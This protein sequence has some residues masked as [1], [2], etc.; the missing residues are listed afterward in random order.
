MKRFLHGHATHPDAG[1]ALAL[2]AAQ[3]DAQRREPG[4]A[5]DP[6]LGWFYLTDHYAPHAEAL[7]ADAQRR[8]PG[9][10]WVGASGIGVAASGVEYIDEPALSLLLGELPRE[11]FRVFSGASPLGAF[12]AH[13]ANVH[14]DPATNDLAELVSDLAA[15]TGAHYLFGGLASGRSRTLHMADAVLG[16]GVSGVAF[17]PEVALVSRVT[18]GCQPLGP[19]RIVTAADR[20]VIMT[21][22]NHPAL[23]A[24][25]GDV[26]LAGVEPR[27]ALPRL[28][29]VLVGLGR[30]DDDAVEAD[31]RSAFDSLH[32]P[33]GSFGTDTRVRHLIGLDP[34]RR[35]IA[36]ADVA[37]VGTPLTFCERH[38]EAARRDL[39][40]I[41][42]EVR[43]EVEPES[44][45][46]ATVAE[47]GGMAGPVASGGGIAG[48]IY[49]SCSGRGG[50][51]FGAPSAELAVVRHALGD[52]P[53]A[54]FFAAG[55]IAHDNL[56][57]YTGVLTVFAA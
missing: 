34:G 15:R 24:L 41:C 4:A 22:D 13:T 26:G 17:G 53:L 39:V 50:A 35:G 27:E 6:T 37:T 57:G 52:V 14:A 38:V 47:R 31:R 3:I 49:V 42:A 40:R 54:G 28:R 46:L 32:R 19:R 33:R 7:L 18:Q 36:I 16:G 23:D 1:V 12:D 56:Y 8:W 45:S 20:N 30:D 44:L 51:H 29:Q 5:D 55:E 25:L 48:A 21:L 43:E 9:V 10:H 11:Q 2:A